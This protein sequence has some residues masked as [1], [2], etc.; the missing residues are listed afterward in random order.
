MGGDSGWDCR[1]VFFLG[2]PYCMSA[3]SKLV[4]LELLGHLQPSECTTLGSLI[5]ESGGN[6]SDSP[7]LLDTKVLVDISTEPTVNRCLYLGLTQSSPNAFSFGA[8][9]SARLCRSPLTSTAQMCPSTVCK[10][11]KA[12]SV[13]D[14][15]GQ[16]QCGSVTVTVHI[17][18]RLHTEE[19]ADSESAGLGGAGVLFL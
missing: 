17:W 11:N 4:L 5:N 16:E 12:V 8:I 3:L 7:C 13:G 19:K 15:W 14:P 9:P 10:V 18:Q 6:I 2:S 1:L